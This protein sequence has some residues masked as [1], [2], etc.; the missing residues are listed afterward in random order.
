MCIYVSSN[1]VF[2]HL[3]FKNVV[4]YTVGD[5]FWNFVAGEAEAWENLRGAT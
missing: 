4:L 5:G 3:H 2:L 1:F